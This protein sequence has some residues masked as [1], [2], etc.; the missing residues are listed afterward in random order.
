MNANI[1][2]GFPCFH[3]YNYLMSRSNLF[4][5]RTVLLLECTVNVFIN[6]YLCRMNKE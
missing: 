5:Y 4:V 2:I 6:T 1:A 3:L